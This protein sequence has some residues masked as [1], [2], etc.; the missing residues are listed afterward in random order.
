MRLRRQYA[1]FQVAVQRA[2]PTPF[3]TNQVLVQVLRVILLVALRW[4]VLE[5]KSSPTFTSVAR[6]RPV[7]VTS[8][9][10]NARTLRHGDFVSVTEV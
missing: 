6:R 7:F 9:A 5:D 1:G 4:R 8:S 2:A 3:S 10:I